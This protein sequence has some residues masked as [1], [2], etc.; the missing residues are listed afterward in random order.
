M[1]MKERPYRENKKYF[2]SDFLSYNTKKIKK[3]ESWGPGHSMT[4]WSR[5]FVPPRVLQADTD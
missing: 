1:L 3:I 4:I 2:L 5:I